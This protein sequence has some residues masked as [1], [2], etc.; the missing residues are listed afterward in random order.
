MVVAVALALPNWS[1]RVFRQM[2]LMFLHL[3]PEYF[4]YLLFLKLDRHST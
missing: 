4:P 1:R 2:V 3:L